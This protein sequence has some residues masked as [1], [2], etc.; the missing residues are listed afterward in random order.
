MPGAFGSLSDY[1]D[2]VQSCLGLVRFGHF[3]DEAATRDD[4]SKIRAPRTREQRKS[5]KELLDVPV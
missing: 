2:Y 4:S 3:V 1:H 5:T